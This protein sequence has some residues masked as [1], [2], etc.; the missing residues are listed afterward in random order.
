MPFTDITVMPVPT[1]S[2]AAH[3]AH[4][5]RVAALFKDH[6]ASA[7]TECWG[8]EVPDGKVTDFK[9]AVA[10]KADETVAVGGVIWPDKPTRD[11]GWEALMKDPRMADMAPVFDGKRMIYAGFDVIAQD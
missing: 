8:E 1:D 2:K 7:V 5:I 10:L 4:A 3:L 9:K 11:A 6:G